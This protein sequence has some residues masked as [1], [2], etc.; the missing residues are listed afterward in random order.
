MPILELAPGCDDPVS[1]HYGPCEGT[2]LAVAQA[3]VDE[4]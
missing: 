3:E 1:G 2:D 4:G